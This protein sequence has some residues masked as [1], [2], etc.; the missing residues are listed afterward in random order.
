MWCDT[1]SRSLHLRGAAGAAWTLHPPADAILKIFAEEVRLSRPPPPPPPG[2][3]KP[4]ASGRSALS[5]GDCR[6]SEITHIPGEKT[7]DRQHCDRPRASQSTHATGAPDTKERNPSKTRATCFP[8]RSG[9][10]PSSSVNLDRYAT[11]LTSW[12]GHRHQRHGSH[13]GRANIL[14][15]G[16]P[17][18]AGGP[19][20]RIPF[21]T[22]FLP[23]S[24][25][26]L[27]C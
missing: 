15:F 8:G 14:D 19:V 23:Q 18:R 25:A 26:C 20:P 13:R 1:R 3:P 22:P 11:A 27:C 24:S 5:Q 10:S 17:T 7:N 4:A 6:A 21:S 12:D 9:D 2:P 16:L